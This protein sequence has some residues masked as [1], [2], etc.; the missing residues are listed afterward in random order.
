MTTLFAAI[1]GVN[2][3]LSWRPVL[4]DFGSNS[5]SAQHMPIAWHGNELWFLS[6]FYGAPVINSD[7]PGFQQPNIHPAHNWNRAP[8]PLVVVQSLQSTPDGI[9]TL[10]AEQNLFAFMGESAEIRI[11]RNKKPERTIKEL[12]QVKTPPNISVGPANVLSISPDGTRLVCDSDFSDE[13][14]LG[15][16]KA[17][18]C[19]FGL[20]LFDVSS[21][22]QI[23]RQSAFEGAFAAVAWSPNSREVAGLTLD[24][25]VFVIDTESGK[26]RLKFHAHQLFGAQIAWSPDGKTLVTATNPRL[27][28]T[29]KHLKF[30]FK[31]G[32][33]F[34]GSGGIRT[35]NAQAPLVIH[36]DSK[37]DATWNTRTER[38]LKRFDARDGKQIGAV[39]TLQ[40][41]ATDIAFSPDGRQLAVGEHEF[42]LV[43]NAQTLTTE[44]RLDIPTPP[45]PPPITSPVCVAWSADSATLALSTE[46]GLMLWRMR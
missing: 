43:L 20:A 23:A 9:A 44:R 33:A 10:S 7:I 34:I 39:L 25:W 5:S 31:S 17:D 28:L 36:T 12:G 1:V 27:M 6:T 26:L 11:W 30:D 3:R 22:R 41:G 2:A 38:A 40:T 35:G 14:R 4:V 32:S 45:T 42:A 8:L 37:G 29:P 15:E 24:G 21:G 16:K 18:F 19:G 13:D 46:R